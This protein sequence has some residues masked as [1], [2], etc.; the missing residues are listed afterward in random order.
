MSAHETCFLAHL[1]C[2]VGNREMREEFNDYFFF[3]YSR[4]E[5]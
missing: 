4:S 3:P 2:F 5:I 1:A